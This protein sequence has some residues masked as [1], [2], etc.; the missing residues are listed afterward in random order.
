M[1]GV[2]ASSR[3]IEIIRKSSLKF[4]TFRRKEH[5]IWCFSTWVRVF[6]WPWLL[7]EV[8][9]FIR[10]QLRLRSNF[11]LLQSFVARVR[12]WSEEIKPTLAMF[13]AR[14]GLQNYSRWKLEGE[15]SK[16][17]ILLQKISTLP[18]SRITAPNFH[19]RNITELYFILVY[20]RPPEFTFCNIFST[21]CFK[22]L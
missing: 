15:S 12:A 1:T 7:I 14:S 11:T 8:Q 6:I 20:W 10:D 19:S 16:T 18:W 17:S 9:T 2:Q 3:G 22:F 5:E 13:L 4:K 21:T